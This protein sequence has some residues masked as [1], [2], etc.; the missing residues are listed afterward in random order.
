MLAIMP[1]KLS[2]GFVDGPYS[3]SVLRY[4]LR[5]ELLGA[6]RGSCQTYRNC[7]RS[8]PAPVKNPPGRP[9][10]AKMQSLYREV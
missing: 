9:T 4:R 10:S 2:R 6:A 5:G 3:F 1:R 7:D 8:A